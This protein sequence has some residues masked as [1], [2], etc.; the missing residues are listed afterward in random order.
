LPRWFTNVAQPTVAR[1]YRAG[2]ELRAPPELTAPVD[3]GVNPAGKDDWGSSTLCNCVPVS[4]PDAAGTED[5][6]PV[7][8]AGNEGV[9][10]EGVGDADEEA[11]AEAVGVTDAFGVTF[12]SE[13]PVNAST[14]TTTEAAPPRVKTFETDDKALPNPFR[15]QHLTTYLLAPTPPPAR[16]PPNPSPGH[17]WCTAPGSA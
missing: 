2:E 17:R 16:L 10:A 13:H 7:D 14:A 3:D 6:G 5:I 12:G 8:A 9:A 15:H 1:S 4:C 11:V